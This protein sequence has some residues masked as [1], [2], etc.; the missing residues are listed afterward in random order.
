MLESLGYLRFLPIETFKILGTLGMLGFADFFPTSNS[1]ILLESMESLG[2]LRGS[3]CLE[4]L[5]G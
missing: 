3:G 5:E 4:S 1:S 2:G